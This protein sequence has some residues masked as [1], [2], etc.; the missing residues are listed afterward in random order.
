MQILELNENGEYMPVEVV[1][2]RDVRTGGIFQLKQVRHYMFMRGYYKLHHC[3]SVSP[4]LLSIVVFYDQ[5]KA[6]HLMTFFFLV[7]GLIQMV[8]RCYFL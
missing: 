4:Q 3:K 8:T 6:K 7:T 1:P 5:N 2:A